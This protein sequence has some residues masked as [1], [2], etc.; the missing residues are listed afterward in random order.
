MD[1]ASKCD[2]SMRQKYKVMN[3]PEYDKA[4]RNRGDITIW[5]TEEA[6][7]AW[8]SLKTGKPRRAT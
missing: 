4:L 1:M 6:I 7:A 8:I 2:Q 3:W 5:I